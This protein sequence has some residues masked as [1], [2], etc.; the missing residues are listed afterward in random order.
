MMDS[1]DGRTIVPTWPTGRS[2]GASLAYRKVLGVTQHLLHTY[3]RLIGARRAIPQY[4]PSF[5]HTL[6]PIESLLSLTEAQ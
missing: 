4:N 2:F 6:T 1:D 5:G 3:K